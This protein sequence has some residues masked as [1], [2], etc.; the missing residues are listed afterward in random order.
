MSSWN[1][2]SACIVC[3]FVYMC[4]CV[5]AVGL[6]GVLNGFASVNDLTVVL[7]WVMR[8]SYQYAF[9]H[10]L[11]VLVGLPELNTLT[12]PKRHSN[13]AILFVTAVPHVLTFSKVFL[14]LAFCPGSGS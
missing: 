5:T 14:R 3:G 4:L 6:V 8:I 7:H 11:F 2:S 13:M 10:C 12:R 1:E 9:E